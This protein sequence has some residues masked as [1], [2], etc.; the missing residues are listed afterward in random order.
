[1]SRQSQIEPRFWETKSLQQMSRA[2][3]EALCDG[4]G[5]CCMAK[6]IDDDTEEIHYTSVACRLFDAQT[7]RCGDYE[8]RQSRVDD[9]VKLTPE[10][11]SQIAWLPKT[12][13]YRLINEGKQLYDW[14][15]LVSGR[16]S[17]VLEAG[18]SVF[19]KI[20]AME[21]DISHDGEYLDHLV[22]P[23]E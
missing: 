19:G 15:P 14:H 16:P 17:S 6:L 8:N 18:V 3:W 11:V 20:S 7:C 23:L 22:E 4:C 5:Q 9:C 13:A 2:E 1:M 10:N 21:Q 12:C